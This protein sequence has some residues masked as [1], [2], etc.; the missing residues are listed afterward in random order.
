MV[1]ID[2]LWSFHVDAVIGAKAAADFLESLHTLVRK[3]ETAFVVI[4]QTQNS[5]PPLEDTPIISWCLQ[6]CGPSALVDQTDVRIGLDAPAVLQR[7]LNAS[8]PGEQ[9]GDEVALVIKGFSPLLGE[10]GPVYLGRVFD[11][12]NGEV[13]GYERLETGYENEPTDPS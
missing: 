12:D 6:G 1:T 5:V 9:L 7:R 4:H 10:F 2:P 13:L 3:Y 11:E 8:K